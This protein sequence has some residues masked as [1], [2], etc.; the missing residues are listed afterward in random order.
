MAG[1]MVRS[2]ELAMRPLP[3]VLL[4]LHEE[5]VTGK[6]TLKRGRVSKTV[7]L[8]SGNPVAA[9]STSREETLGHFLVSSGMITEEEHR[10]AVTHVAEFGGKLGAALVALQ[11]LTPRQLI[12]QLAKQTRHKLVQALR[13]PQG[14]WRFDASNAAIEGMQLDMIEV[15]LSGLCE[16]VVGDLDRL[17]R[18]DGMSF[19]LTSRGAGLRTELERA[20]GERGVGALTAG[21][22]ISE[23]ERAFPDPT[24]ARIAIDTMMLC[25][26][27]QPG[28]GQVGLGTAAGRPGFAI[29]PMSADL[30]AAILPRR[31]QTPSA[32]FE[33][34]FDDLGVGSDG[35]APLD[36]AEA[37]HS[38]PVD[39]L[40]GGDSG[41]VSMAELTEASHDR[42]RVARAREMLSAEH[43]RIQGAD[44]YSVLMISRRAQPGEIET[45]ATARNHQVEPDIAVLTEPRERAKLAELL[46]AY[47]TARAVLL[48]DRKRAAYD[49]ELAGGELVQVPPAIDTELSFR[50]AEDLFASKQWA[51]AIGLIRAVI[52]R[53][54][55]EADYHAALGWAE[56]MG[57]DQS[58]AAADLARPHL[59]AAL[60][61]NPD[62]AA[63]HEYKGRIDAAMQSDDAAALFHLE[64]AIDLDPNRIEAVAAIENLLTRRGE[65]RRYERVLKRLLFRLR[66]RGNLAEAKAWARLARLYFE[67]L[68]DR[69]AGAAA[70][71]NAHRIAP[72]DSEVVAL[73]KRTETPGPSHVT[74]EPIREGWREAL[75]DPASGAALVKS[76]EA[77]GHADAAFLAASTMVA[78]GTAD[79]QLASLYEAHRVRGAVLPTRALG[80]EQWALLRHRDDNLELGGLIEL[81][82][83]A[84][85]RL[86]PMTLADSELDASQRIEDGDLPDSFQR[87][88]LRCA[89]LLGVEP[90]PVYPRVE[91]GFQIHVV[92]CDPPVLVAGDEALTA[93]DRPELVFRLVRAMTFLW[94]GRAV[95]ASRSG[96]VLRAIVMAVFR[97][98]SGSSVG[99][100]DPLAEQAADA[101]SQLSGQARVH[102]RAVALRLMSRGNGLNLSL[103]ARGLSRT[104][105]RAGM[106]MC[107]D[108]PAAFA[109]ALEVGELD[110]DAIEF[111]F[112]AAHV[113]LR[114]QLGLAR[115]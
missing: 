95:G 72:R 100:E 81:V 108:I 51:R 16:T 107:G 24:Q 33:V 82:A 93:P 104:A 25:G 102:A 86:S 6:L 53:S 61:I 90:P 99:I 3:A 64:R 110:R 10:H 91:L 20:F 45:A 66:S 88:R 59:N 11:M 77:L 115:S 80:R 60:E 69:Q 109:G 38:A 36:L 94:P 105:D 103:W 55:D 56:W 85:H 62:H 57:G 46:Q 78:L 31:A 67:Q 21:A 19:E 92:A 84:I 71:S 74:G 2:G 18:L 32:L 1:A 42:D 73:T 54:P 14:A 28:V 22:S 43:Q 8:V 17:S 87:L 76:T 26:A 106:L 111:A 97:E 58:P 48:D 7:D 40:L 9:A 114:S 47:A 75:G 113:Q 37:D 34:L 15:V 39:D 12:E 96:R 4:D 30:P 41:V 98:A 101:V 83:P 29:P 13:W 68:D 65:L 44:H 112:G 35:A 52:A 63:A 27:A 23:L 49:R 79:E 89:D 70:A 50:M 5:L